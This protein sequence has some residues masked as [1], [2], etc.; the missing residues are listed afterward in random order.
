M[1]SDQLCVKHKSLEGVS[2]LINAEGGVSLPFAC[3][4]YAN[5]SD[6]DS[7]AISH[8]MHL[9]RSFTSVILSRRIAG[10]KIEILYNSSLT[11]RARTHK[12]KFYQSYGETYSHHAFRN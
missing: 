6:A 8:A 9:A 3:S 7:G 2:Y 4:L 11:R 12:N 10:G 1:T 5:I